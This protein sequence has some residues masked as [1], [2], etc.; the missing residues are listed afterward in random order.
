MLARTAA[1]LALAFLA[2]LASAQQTQPPQTQPQHQI[3]ALQDG[4]VRQV[5]ES[6]VIPP[7]S[8]EP[9]TA[10]LV[11]EWSRYT[12]DG[13]TVTLI[14]QRKVARDAQGRLYEERWLLVPKGG[15]IPS[16]M[17]WIQIAD[18]A[19]HTLLNCNVFRHVCEQTRWDPNS[20]LAAATPPLP[21]SGPLAN[22]RGAIESVNLGSRTMDDIDTTGT[23]ITTTF[24]PGVMGNDKP[25]QEVRETWRSAQLALNLLSIRSGPMIGKQTFTMTELDPGDPDPQLFNLPAGY[26]LRDL[27]T[28][29]SGTP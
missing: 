3:F 12:A 14:N 21:V 7:I 26:S 24:N 23:R 2:S 8:G 1:P 28:P 9:F 4:G 16:R 19:Q 20:E 15:S 25:V 5:M 11:T 29:Q 18:P 22:D 13:G 6:I 17:N 10:T 27:R